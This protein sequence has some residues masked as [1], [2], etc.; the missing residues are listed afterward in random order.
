MKLCVIMNHNPS[1]EVSRL[2]RAAELEFS[3]VGTAMMTL[4]DEMMTVPVSTG[5][6][7][8]WLLCDSLQESHG[9]LEEHTD[10]LL[11]P[12]N[13]LCKQLLCRNNLHAMSHSSQE[14]C[15]MIGWLDL[16]T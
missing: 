9:R 11:K 12:S 1:E 5:D 4:E 7:R 10:S 6:S 13:Y 15:L 16:G 3:Q 2:N 8:Y 14:S